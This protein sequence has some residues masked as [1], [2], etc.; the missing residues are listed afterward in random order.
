MAGTMTTT[1]LSLA[2]FDVDKTAMA[3]LLA[4]T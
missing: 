1:T 4:G 3:E 2:V